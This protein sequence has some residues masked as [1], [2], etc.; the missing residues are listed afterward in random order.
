MRNRY[1][2]LINGYKEALSGKT[3][4]NERN[5]RMELREKELDC[6]IVKDLLPLYIFRFIEFH[7]SKFRT[8]N[9]F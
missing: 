3:E 5:E 9:R 4:N 8:T 7:I 1:F 6:E 2:P